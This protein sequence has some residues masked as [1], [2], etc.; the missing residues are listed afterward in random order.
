MQEQILYEACVFCIVR[1]II[2][3][4]VWDFEVVFFLGG[5]SVCKL[6][7]CTETGHF[8]VI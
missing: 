7:L 6:K 1:L 2:M 4:M 3:A 5:R 8:K